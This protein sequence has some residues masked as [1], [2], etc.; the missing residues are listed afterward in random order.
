M[1]TADAVYHVEIVYFKDKNMQMFTLL[2]LRIE[3][4][5]CVLVLKSKK[6]RLLCNIL[7]KSIPWIQIM[8]K[9]S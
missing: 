4:G 3:G 7:E 6:A 2:K 9:K 5:D 1:R 8:A